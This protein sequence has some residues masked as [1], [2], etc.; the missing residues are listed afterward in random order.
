MSTIIK[1]RPHILKPNLKNE[2]PRYLLA[3]DT[4]TQ[5]EKI[6]DETEKHVLK[7][8]YA[9]FYDRLHRKKEYFYFESPEDFW[10]FVLSKTKP[11]TKLYIFAHNFDFDWQ[12]LQGWQFLPKTIKG[13]YKTTIFD[14]SNF[15]INYRCENKCSL[16]FLSTTNYFKTSLGE[17]GKLLG[18]NKMDVDFSCTSKQYLKEY[19]KRDTEIV[20]EIIKYY[21]QFLKHHDLGNFKYTAAG[22]SFTAYRHR[23]MRDK[24]YI[25]S[26]P[27]VVALERESYRGGRN[28]CFFI[29]R[30]EGDTVY[31][32]DINSMYPFVMKTYEY[33]TKLIKHFKN[34]PVQRLYEFMKEYLVIARLKISI[35]KPCIGKKQKKLIFPTGT[36][37]CVLCSPEI[38]LVKKYGEI[39]QVEE[40]ALYEKGEIF[41][42]FI[43]FFYNL[44]LKH[45]QEGNEIMQFFDKLLMNSLYGKFGQKTELFK[46]AGFTERGHYEIQKVYDMDSRKWLYRKI[47]DGKVYEKEGYQEGTD[48]FV[49]IASFVTAYARCYLWRLIE[50]AGENNVFYCDTDSL[51]VNK[52]GYENLKQYINSKELGKLKVEDISEFLEIRNCKDYTFGKETK[53]KGVRKDA[54]EISE[55]EFKQVQF[56]KN[57]GNL[58]DY[59]EDGAIVKT[60]IKKLKGTYDKG[61]VQNNGKVIP[62]RL[63]E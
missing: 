37:E 41:K 33:P 55:N 56:V 63:N 62:I 47:I 38:E 52:Q 43:N 36:F 25:H 42:D 23:F 12:V 28:E 15:I 49:A 29:G 44:R 3:V 14:S 58:S 48:S 24:I 59:K 54:E 20:L 31:K 30:I 16:V 26:N 45:K 53:R 7:L 17:L 40:V 22:Q 19:C 18:L 46:E 39:L 11:K 4:E 21:L 2:L 5:P 27:A 57:R 35:N 10:K 6:D 60:I 61:V 51:F 13:E 8:G 1:R 34:V 32:L 9:I 50:T